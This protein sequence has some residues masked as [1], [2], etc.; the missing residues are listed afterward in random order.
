MNKVILIGR[1]TKDPELKEIKDG[2]TQFCKF[3]LAVN[4]GHINENGERDVDFIPVIIWGKQAIVF[5][6]YMKKGSLV[7]ITGKLKIRS[8]EDSENNRKYFSEVLTEE[9]QFLESKNKREIS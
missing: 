5:A 9:F 7:S 3:S 2:S 8:F 4:N 6:N 1:L